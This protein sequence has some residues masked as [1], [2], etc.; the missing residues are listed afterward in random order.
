MAGLGSIG[1]RFYL[2]WKAIEKPHTESFD[3]QI[4]FKEKVINLV[5][6]WKAERATWKDIMDCY[7]QL[8]AIILSLPICK[9]YFNLQESRWS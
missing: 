3:K 9:R 8:K 4:Q 7:F 1:L 2:K 6:F 5:P